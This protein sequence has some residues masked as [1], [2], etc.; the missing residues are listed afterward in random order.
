MSERNAKVFLLAV[1]TFAVVAQVVFVVVLAKLGAPT[2]AI[3]IY[4]ALAGQATNSSRN[5]TR[6]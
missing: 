5:T 6:Q 2:W 3:L 1:F 4:L